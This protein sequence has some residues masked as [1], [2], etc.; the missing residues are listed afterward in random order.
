MAIAQ[1]DYDRFETVVV[2]C[3][4]GVAVANEFATVRVIGFDQPN[5][6]AARNLGVDAASG[7]VVAF[8]DD[9][10]IPEPT[11]LHHLAEGFADP[12]VAQA[13]GTTLGRN[14]ISV[15][16]GAALVDATGQSHEV[17]IGDEAPVV[18]TS[19]P[20]RHPRLHGTNMALRRAIVQHHGGFDERFAFYLDETDLTYRVSRSG[21]TTLFV[22]K[23]VVHHASGPSRFRSR[24]RTPQ[25]VFEIAASAA[26]FHGKHC[27]SE[28]R[29]SAR[30]AFLTERRRWILRHMQGG[31]LPPDRAAHLIRDLTAGYQSGQT[32]RAAPARLWGTGEKPVIAKSIPYAQ[33]LYLVATGRS[34]ARSHAEARALVAQG[35]RVT[36]FEY[37]PDA[38]YHRVVFTDEGY[39]LH[40]G[41][42][43]GREDRSEPLFRA[44]TRQNR[45]DQTLARLAGIRSKNPYLLEVKT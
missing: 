13:G 5:I 2:A 41:G 25:D 28:M 14:G 27:A 15:Q 6:S 37:R 3:P 42:I 9:D 33:D 4:K 43:F 22:P 8:I 38:R 44:S 39:W 23:A 21:G 12:D 1:L 10:A 16:H 20:D 29:D 17:H 26:V 7:D 32:R 34:K 19:T 18:L 35:H 11:W 36:V 24:D 30:E 31:G 45:I 40:I